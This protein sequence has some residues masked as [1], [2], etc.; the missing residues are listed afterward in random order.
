MPHASDSG[1][2]PGGWEPRLNQQ[3][4]HVWRFGI[5]GTSAEVERLRPL[6]DENERKRGDRYHFRRDRGRFIIARARLRILLGR[7]VSAAPQTLRFRYGPMGKP[8]LIAAS[9]ETVPCFSLSHSDGMCVIAVGTR[10][11]GVDIERTRPVESPD[12]FPG[13]LAPGELAALRAIP[14]SLRQEAFFACWTRKEAWLKA[15]GDGL[16]FGLDRFEV[17]VEPDSPPALLWVENAPA[18]VSR[19]AMHQLCVAPDYRGALAVE[20]SGC[21]LRCLDFAE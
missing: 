14:A 7:Y 20:G 11:V 17:S 4:V 1:W 21:R 16:R 5:D 12:S 13:A 8:E 10:N 2:S 18:E 19:W 9:N 6:L 3:E 15:R